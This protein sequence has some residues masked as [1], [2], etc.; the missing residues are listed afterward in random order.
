MSL[1]GDLTTP[2]AQ[3]MSQAIIGTDDMTLTAKTF[4]RDELRRDPR[5]VFEMYDRLERHV[6]S[7][8]SP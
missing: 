4:G 3:A 8:T 6:L 1:W 5:L 7:R 2:H